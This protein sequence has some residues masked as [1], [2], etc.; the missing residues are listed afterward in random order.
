M[1]EVP[2][3]GLFGVLWLGVGLSATGVAVAGPMVSLPVLSREALSEV[4]D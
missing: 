1:P 2:T 3:A 4:A